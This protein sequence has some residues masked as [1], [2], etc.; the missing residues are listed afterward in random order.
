MSG[1]AM[2]DEVSDGV[3]DVKWCKA[4]AAGAGLLRNRIVQCGRML[5]ADGECPNA[6]NHMYM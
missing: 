6:A 2:P 4:L 5:D 1:G 3:P